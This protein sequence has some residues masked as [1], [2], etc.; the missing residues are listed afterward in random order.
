MPISATK[1]ARSGH[2]ATDELLYLCLSVRR[3]TPFFE[4]D[5]QFRRLGQP[6]NH[7][8]GRHCPEAPSWSRAG[9]IAA[10]DDAVRAGAARSNESRST[11]DLSSTRSMKTSAKGFAKAV[12]PRLG[13]VAWNRVELMKSS[14]S[15]HQYDSMSAIG[16]LWN[17]SVVGPFIAGSA[18]ITKPT[19][20]QC[21][22]A[23]LT[24]A[25]A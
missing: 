4:V 3:L 20:S 10:R 21:L 17:L 5:P 14:I 6:L 11:L 22:Q 24:T 15:C 25:W 12:R 2:P 18:Q 19:W 9:G 1:S 8:S 23:I 13:I 7:G 16:N